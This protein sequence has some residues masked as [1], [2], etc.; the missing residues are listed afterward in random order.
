MNIDFIT[1]ISKNSA[2][3]AEYLKYTC[4]KF[5]SKKHHIN[6]LAV[7]SV[8]AERWPN[9]YKKLAKAGDGGHNSMTHSVALNLAQNYVTS[10]YVIF[11]DADMAILYQNWDDVIVNELNKYDCFGVSYAD[12]EL[13]YRNFPTVYLFCFRKHILDQ[14]KL[15]FSPQI[16]KGKDAPNRYKISSDEAKIFDRKP[17]SLIKCDTGWKLPLLIKSMN[18]TSNSLPMILMTSKKSQ[19]PFEDAAHK[20]FCLQKPTHHAEWHYNGKLFTTH[21]QASRNHP[22]GGD[23]GISWKKRID[24]YIKRIING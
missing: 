18:F 1:F 22:L 11:I 2:D 3:Y 15:D 8:G 14:T 19:L 12:N 13:K 16:T 21:K 5:L 10:D 23:W 4:E 24:M 9:G 17:G 6:W 7:E 20:K